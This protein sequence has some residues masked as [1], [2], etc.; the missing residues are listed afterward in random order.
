VQPARYF[1][2]QIAPHAPGAIGPVARREAGTNLRADILIAPAA[3]SCQPG[4]ES[5]YHELETSFVVAWIVVGEL[6][7]PKIKNHDASP[8]RLEG[9]KTMAVLAHGAYS[10]N[11]EQY[12]HS[13]IERHGKAPSHNPDSGELK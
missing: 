13:M 4:I 7:G 8:I 9:A 10:K 1:G 2:E 6:F 11:I 3:R 5:H 12:D